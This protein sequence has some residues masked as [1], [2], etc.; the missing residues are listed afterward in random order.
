MPEQFSALG[1]LQRLIASAALDCRYAARA[2]RRQPGFSATIALT[3]ALGLGLNATVLGMMDALLLRPFQFPDYE[4]LVVIWETPAGSRERQNVAPANYLDWRA[5]LRSVE[6]LTAWEGWAATLTGRDEPERLQAVRVSPGFFE[7]LGTYPAIGRPLAVGEE[8]PGQDRTVVIGDGL[9]KRRFGAAPGVLGTRILLDGAPYTVVGVA[10]EGFDFPVGCELWAPLAIGPERAADRRTRSLTVLGKL[11]P[12]RSVGHAQ[13]E[14]D[15]I[16]RRLAQQYPDSNRDRGASVRTLSTAFREEGSSAFVGIL[17]AGA[18]LVL[19]IACANLA[20]LLLARAHD[21]QRE[22]AVRSA[23]GGGRIRLVRQIVTETAL[24][25]L[26]ASAGALALAYAGLEVLRASMPADLAMHIEGWN[27]VRLD[28]RL[29]IAVPALAIGLGV[30]V[31]LI[32]AA[33]ASRTS[34]SDALRDGDRGSTG[35]I[36]RQ[37]I[38]RGLVVAEIAFALALLVASGLALRA[39]VR[40]VRQ[41]GGFDAERLL[42]FSLSLAGSRYPDAGARREIAVAIQERLSATPGVEDVALASVL[43]A[44]GWNPVVPLLIAGDPAPDASRRPHAGFR[45]VS[46]GFFDAMRIPL[47]AGR[48]FTGADRQDAPG[49]AV[50]SASAAARFWPGRD[51]LGARLQVGDPPSDWITI[52]GV[53]DDVTMYNWWDGVDYTAVYVPL[54]QVPGV[55]ELSAAVRTRGEPAA[56]TRTVRA[57]VASLDPALAIHGA[58]T[59][60]EAIETSTF[61]LSFMGTLMAACGALALALS[62][63]GVYS[64]MA[65][66]VSQRRHEFGVRMALG[67]TAQDVVW[68]TLRQAGWLTALGVGLGLVMALMLGRLMSSAMEGV[69]SL[70]ALTYVAVAGV[71]ALVSFGAACVPARRSLRLDPSVILRAQ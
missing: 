41:P 19:I 39:G 14:I 43:P 67:A 51:P 40:M 7:A 30:L 37:R 9:W 8:Q 22:F 42:T 53:V 44:A 58:R 24:L 47:L 38:R 70:D 15:V 25:G 12:G 50:V 49:V 4:H 48:A 66:A 61:G 60:E 45:V 68:L 65:Y 23:L 21:R 35:G 6:G 26:V 56:M 33:A 55:G 54:L 17:Q 20:G 3:L 52:V 28:H 62:L 5:G 32:P 64:M 16:S 57:A 71:L 1:T 13:A 34:V 63:V 69:V 27:N 11:A 29:F 2:L 46:A 18:G 59:M 36:R 10:P 31:G